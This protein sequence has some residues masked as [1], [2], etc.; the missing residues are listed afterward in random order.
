VAE[1]RTVPIRSFHVC[2]QLERR[3]HKIDRWRVPVSY[4]IPLRGIGY[5][6]L[7]LLALLML[8]PFPIV[9]SLIGALHPALRFIVIPVG[10]AYTLMRWTVDGRPAHRFLLAWARL[11]LAPS[12]VSAF[13][14]SPAP[15]PVV[16]E[17]ITFAPDERSANLRP[18]VVRG[19]ASVLVRYP[20]RMRQR[21]RT[22]HLTREAGPPLWRGKQIGVEPGQR[23]IVR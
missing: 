10:V 5:A 11:Q 1:D 22:L 8:T 9:G 3:I 15:G 23:V 18:A 6:A 17:A 21:G 20:S 16:L 19:P 2:F 14:A 13:R 7:T 12:R 4:G